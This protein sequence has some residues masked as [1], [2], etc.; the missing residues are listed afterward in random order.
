MK[1]IEFLKQQGIDVVSSLELFGDIATY[2]LSLKDF[3]EDINDKI[4][5]LKNNKEI[6]NM[7]NYAI[8]VH[9]LKSD[10][11]YFGFTQ[12]AQL[13]YQHELESKANH[14]YFIYEHYDSLIKEV[15]RIIRIVKE[16]MGQEITPEMEVAEVVEILNETIIVVDDSNV[17]R[18]FIRKL[19][20][21]KYHVLIAHDGKE[22]IQILEQVN[23]NE[24]TTMLLDLN[25]PN[26]NG[27]QVLEYLNHH[28]LFEEIPVS[29]ITGVGDDHIINNVKNYPISGILRKPFNEK[30]VKAAIEYAAK[31]K[32]QQ[33][34]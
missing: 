30:S 25:M 20:D 11:K 4:S 16:Y 5:Q 9:S 3:L 1:E 6:A 27:F 33:V 21:A 14:I 19:F 28:H 7:A 8:V 17:I 29:I 32:A 10:A 26:V 13:A 23:H 24:I 34:S 12:L 18:N 31:K 15:K 22:A 2:N